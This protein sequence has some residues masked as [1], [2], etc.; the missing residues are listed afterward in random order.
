[1]AELQEVFKSGGVPSVTFVKP[2][3]YPRILLNL[4]T[5]GR[6]LVIEGPSGI[7]KTTAVLK[8]IEEL[9][10]SDKVVRL[11][12]RKKEDLEYIKLIPELQDIG[13]VLV[14]DFHVLADDIK[15]N[16]ADLVKVFAD[17]E[18][19]TSKLIVLGINQAGHSLIKFAPDLVNRI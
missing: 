19:E 13:I 4:R 18:A 12:A 8:A 16:I 10:F 7:G 5:P 3:E 1:M 17:E 11:S 15:S 6:G 2:V 14:D 9:G